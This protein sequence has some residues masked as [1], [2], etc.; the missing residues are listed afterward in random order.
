MILLGEFY[1][2]REHLSIFHLPTY[3]YSNPTTLNRAAHRLDHRSGGLGV[4]QEYLAVVVDKPIATFNTM[5]HEHTVSAVVNGPLCHLAVWILAQAGNIDD[6]SFKHFSVHGRS[7]GRIERR[8]PE[9]S[10]PHADDLQHA[11]RH[12]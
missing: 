3:A 5:A 6:I 8:K 12:A 4:Q 11:D 7:A 9:Q 1:A 2:S 10:R